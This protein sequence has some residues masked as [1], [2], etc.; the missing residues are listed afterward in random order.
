MIW[1]RLAPYGIFAALL[2]GGLWYVYHKGEINE[3]SSTAGKVLQETE[4]QR[5]AREAID[6]RNRALDDAAATER[7][8][9]AAP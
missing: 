6:A 8:R 5:K 1:L 2:L 9:P 4:A 3:R 7:L